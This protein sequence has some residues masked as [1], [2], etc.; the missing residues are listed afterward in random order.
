[1][2]QAPA[3]SKAPDAA[4]SRKE[5]GL[6]ATT[7]ARPAASG[8]T[9][10][11]NLATMRY[12]ARCAANRSLTFRMSESGSRENRLRVSNARGPFARPSEYQSTSA[13]RVAVVAAT[14]ETARFM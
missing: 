13:A 2:I 3:Q 1:M 14:M 9:Q 10:G 6:R 12:L 4:Y 8:F 5:A 7:P 11:K